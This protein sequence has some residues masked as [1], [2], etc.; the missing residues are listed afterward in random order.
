MFPSLTMTKTMIKKSLR[1]YISRRQLIFLVLSHRKVVGLAGFQFV[2]H[3]VNGIFIFLIIFSDFHAVNHLDEGGKVLFLYRS[4]VVDVPDESA[5]QQRLSLHPEIV[6]G[7]ALA[8]GIGD[9]G[10]DQLQDVLL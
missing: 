3:Q 6:P 2:E 8:L 9:Q 7:L 1:A 4:L 5:V 10:R